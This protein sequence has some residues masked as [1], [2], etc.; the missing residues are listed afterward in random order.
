VA[1][2]KND[3][4]KKL[5]V[6]FL[7]VF[8]IQFGVTGQVGNNLFDDSYVHEIH[9]E[10]YDSD[11]LSTMYDLH[12]TAHAMGGN[13]D[14]IM[15]AITI[16]GEEATTLGNTLDTVGV[17]MKGDFSFVLSPN[18][19]KPLKIDINEFV[20]GQKYD[21]LKKFNLAPAAGDPSFLREKIGY[22]LHQHLG[23]K[24]PRCAFAK[25]YL[26]GEY[27][28]LYQIIEQVDKTFL[29]DRFG[30]KD[31]NLFK[32]QGGASL[33]WIDDNQSTYEDE[34][35]PKY[36]LKT[37][38][39][40]NDWSDL[41]AFMKLLDN[42][43]D[44]EFKEV[45]EE[46]FNVA[47]FLKDLAVQNYIMNNDNYFHGG[48]NYYLYHN[49]E[50]QKW[51]WIPWD[52]NNSMT[53]Y[54]GFGVTN[55]TPQTVPMIESSML[56]DFDPLTRR[57][58][59]ND[60]LKNQY[61]NEVCQLVNG[62]G[63]VSSIHT[64]IDELADMIRDDVY[65]DTRKKYTNEDFE[66]NIA[67]IGVEEVFI[68]TMHGVKDFTEKRANKLSGEL[69]DLG[70]TSC[71]NTTSAE[72]LIEE[73]TYLSLYPNPASDNL[74]ITI[75]GIEESDIRSIKIVDMLGNEILDIDEKS[76]LNTTSQKIELLISGTYIL[77]LY[78]QKGVVFTE[79]FVK[80]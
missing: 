33:Q 27:W 15:A 47:G 24:A 8:F 58:L 14:Y 76:I 7:S 53:N 54:S 56:G 19:K 30:N 48:N 63:S 78:T 39:T 61:Y 13:A 3:K 55:S 73:K 49:T 2:A 20:S 38:K 18:D 65:A 6:L 57:I 80:Q 11:F 72:N 23:V 44:A 41:I 1:H 50:T 22:E 45:L 43:P 42:T 40:E 12:N 71:M 77:M 52:L 16:D 17:R 74:T 64:R 4:M 66:N 29:K 21:E 68:G 26:N 36:E 67:Y 46:H 70:I 37:N 51:E 79:K 34:A 9:L 75:Y 62:F 31:G 60:E 69:T 10:F 5:I 28:G 59:E 35:F 25:I 32:S